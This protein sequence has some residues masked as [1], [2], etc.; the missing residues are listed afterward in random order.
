MIEEYT[1]PARYVENGNIITKPALSDTEYLEFD[2]VGTLEAFN[3]DGLR[4]LMFTMKIPNMIEK[5]LRYPHHIEYIKVLKDSGFFSEEEIE[6]RGQFIK[7][8]EFTSKILFDK[9]K[10]NEDD[11]EFTVMRIIIEG[12]KDNKPKKYIYNLFDKNDKA[13]KTSSMART[14]GYTATAVANL[15]LNGFFNRKGIIPPEYL[16]ED[17]KSFNFIIDYLKERNIYYHRSEE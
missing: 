14:T 8:L 3:T 9:W 5:T 10:L 17:E 4:S 13:T 11:D 6:F 7:P 12:E 1:R 16:G 2:E 15:F